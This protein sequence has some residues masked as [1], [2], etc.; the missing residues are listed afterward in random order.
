M[1]E[2]VL[3]IAQGLVTKPESVVVTEDET[4]GEFQLKLSVAPEDMGKVIGRGG[5]T[6]RDI[7]VILR[8]IGGYRGKLVNLEIVENGQIS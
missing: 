4:E 2:I 3:Y 6:A 1:R 8:A 5:R 7:R